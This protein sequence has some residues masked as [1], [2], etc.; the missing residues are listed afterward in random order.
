M[1]DKT[2]EKN[3]DEIKK[4]K[5][6][7]DAK[8]VDAEEEAITNSSFIGLYRFSTRCDKFL[9][10][11]GVINALVSGALQPLNNILFGD[12]IQEIVNY[13]IGLSSAE[14]MMEAIRY[15]ALWNTVIGIGIFITSYIAAET[16][17]YTAIKQI[18]RVRS[19]YV[20]KLLNKD[21]PWFDVHQSGDFASR[22]A[23]DLS[24]FEDGIG[25]K[26]PLFLILQATFVA[27]LVIA[28]TRGWELALI[29]LTSLPL[30]LI[31]VGLIFFLSTKLS[32]NELD[33]YASAGSIAEEVLTSIR[34]VVAFG[35]QLLEKKRYDDNLDIAKK[36]NIK[37]SFFEALGFAVLWF[38]IYASYGLAFWYGVGLVLS[39]D[40]RYSS[41]NAGNMI[42]V[43]FSVMAGSMSFGVASPFIEAFSMAKAAGGKVFHIIDGLPKIN[44]SKNNGE[45]LPQVRG[46][47][48]FQDVNF[49]YPSRKDVPILQGINIEINPGE[50]VALVGSSGCGKS[51]VLQLIQRFYDPLSGKV[52]IDGKDLRDLDL[53]WYRKNIGVVSQEPIL[54]D[55]TIEENIRYGNTEATEKDIIEA[56][57]MANAHGFIKKLPSGYKTL[58]GERGAQLSGGQ[59]QRIAIARAL[60]RN[61]AILLLD[62]ATSALDTNS[63]AKVQAA[64]DKASQNRT[65]IIVAHRL[66]TI[67][68][69]NKI[70]VVSN[71]KVVEEG[72]HEQLL[73]LGG[74]YFTLVTTQVQ[75]NEE[76]KNTNYGDEK[77][78][79]LDDFKDDTEEE[80]IVNVANNE[81]DSDS[82][83]KKASLW[84]IV[85][86]NSPEWFLLFLGS[87]GAALMG[88]SMPIFAILFGNIVQVFD[89]P[90]HD[91]VRSETDKYSL[92]FVLAGVLAMV[93]TFLQMYMFGRAGQKLTYRIRSRMFQAMLKQEMGY[94][95]RKENGV[96]ALCAQLSNEA[97][98]VQGATGQRIGAI[99]NSAS[100]L[101]LAVGL[102]MYY[103]WKLGLVALSFFPL[104]VIATFLQR[105]QMAGEN[106]AY[107]KSLE[108][109][110][111]IAVEG[112]GNIRTVVSLGCEKIFYNLY[113]DE[114]APHIKTSLRATH[115]RSLVL[116]FSRAIILFAFS[117]CLY[118]GGFLIRDDR[119]PY[120]DVMKVAQAL[121]MGTVSIANSL[122]FT[123][124]LEKG[125]IAAKKVMTLINRIPRVDDAM[126][127]IAKEKADG[128]ITYSDIYFHY[129]TR[130]NIQVL[131]GLDLS[132]LQGK[133]VALV[134][135]SGCG[136]STIV[137]LIERFYDPKSGTVSLDDQNIK[138]ITLASLR[139]H[140]GIVSQEPN[141]FSRTIGE[142][143]AYGDTGR[144]VSMAEIMEAA[145]NANIHNFITQL[146]LGYNTQLG[147]KGTQLSGGQK[148][149]IAIARALIR[150]PKVL[151]LDEATSALDVESEKIVQEALDN[152]KQGRT[153]ITIAHRLTT[154]QDADLICVISE[155][156]V[157]EQGTHKELI[158]KR[159]LYFGLHALQ[160]S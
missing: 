113:I 96:G 94:F 131:K 144:E 34:T 54:F 12:L 148:Q 106:E 116:G 143:I 38:F 68:G 58:V 15:F 44:L 9:L 30:S 10:F 53:T 84:S 70:F 35:G 87:L 59:K 151:L 153:C 64:L 69:A 19:N 122:A 63:E 117:A 156:K 73:K 108:R 103:Q 26:V 33:A 133:T 97:A 115:S 71:G 76:F 66:S 124:N 89:N 28:L 135:P 56:S 149:R 74:H 2:E 48:K 91:Y 39:D 20:E 155:G 5:S 21:V 62:E 18:L 67:R 57:M 119:V 81:A 51:T 157:A 112:V 16:F 98:Q 125:L 72:T 104:I 23:D 40:P 11:I 27:S 8:F 83:V 140:L 154:I 141:L 93:A 145:T 60:V 6:K 24:K 121:I 90:D 138:S 99:V 85:K 31:A 120:G 158:Q 77:S 22:M 111:K 78:T 7:L 146:P 118:Y 134:G 29:C 105:R 75:G 36:N 50:T 46:N 65:T 13:A 32:K 130:E 17:N 4:D 128:N 159:G 110:T 61:P 137:Q 47:I 126:G 129:P 86:L 102:A 132:V 127:A 49:H 37:R 1:A 43:F 42:T 101:F 142:N 52:F 147:E 45:K 92:Y 160:S 150:N 95:D 100:T 55:T 88:F 41:Y 139:S 114:L 109:S 136:K 25:E 123:P 82:F 79:L 152:A 107:R 3:T 14:T 80:I